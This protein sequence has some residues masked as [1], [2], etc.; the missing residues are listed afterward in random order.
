MTAVGIVSSARRHVRKGSHSTRAG[1]GEDPTAA[2]DFVDKLETFKA[3][4]DRLCNALLD[5]SAA[6]GAISW[7]RGTLVA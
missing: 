7:T 1:L 4:I 2:S 6:G 5:P 3:G